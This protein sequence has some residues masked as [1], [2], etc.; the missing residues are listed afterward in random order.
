MNIVQGLISVM[1][2]CIIGI[3]VVVPIVADIIENATTLTGVSLTLANIV[4][5]LI[6]VVIIVA[7]VSMITGQ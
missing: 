2:A 3:A 4:V 5:P 1:I 6:L 7:I